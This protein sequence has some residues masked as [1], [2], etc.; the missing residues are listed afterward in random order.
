MVHEVRSPRDLIELPYSFT[1]LGLLPADKFIKEA[2]TRDIDIRPAALE[3]LHR[4][5]LLPP[6]LRVSRNRRAILRAARTQP[7]LAHQLAHWTG[8][9]AWSLRQD[10]AEGRVHDGFAERFTARERLRRT[11]GDD[12]YQA[13]YFLYSPH[14]LMLL[15]VL[16]GG[17]PHLAYDDAGRVVGIDVNKLW[18]SFARTRLDQGRE[19][20]VAV[21][22]LEARYL[23]T[24]TGR[25]ALQSS[26]EFVEYDRWRERQRLG[27]TLRWLGVRPAWL[28]DSAQGLLRHA[29]S[30]DPL[31]DWFDLV[32][33]ADPEWWGRLSGRAR[34]AIDLRIAAEILLRYYD[35]LARAGRAAPLPADEP[36]ARLVRTDFD[37]RLRPKRRLDELLTHFGLSPHPAV[38]LVLEGATEMLLV[39]R[40]MQLLGVRTS[41]DYI[42]VQDAEGVTTSISS[43]VAY[44]IAPRGV[45]DDSGRYIMLTRPLTR[46]VSVTDAEGPRATAA[47]RSEQRKTWVERMLRTLPTEQR[48]GEVR[49][50]LERLV[51]VLVWNRAGASFEFAHFS[52]RQIAVAID[53]LDRRPRRPALAKLTELVHKLRVCRGNLDNLLHGTSKPE[54]ADAL[55]PVLKSKIDRALT[56][57]TDGHI[58]VVRVVDRA[59]ELAR[60]MPRRNVVI[61]VKRR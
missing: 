33:E 42:R 20:V 55:W 61:P 50:S 4:L 57:G 27:S 40:V 41:D 32:R 51:H 36:G 34:S 11:V 45:L 28:R 52:D 38:L 5:G 29:R 24:I 39:P 25:L 54:L 23:P 58:P 9:Q 56:R 18:L 30:I 8:T 31:G 37:R 60:E 1:Q 16:A 48:T 49:G 44:A 59:A 47:Q 2:K 10:H 22:A 17:L 19:I 13:S 26:I 46:L 43:L 6:M 21:S 12:E 14:Q 35:D 7:M 53:A 15:P 3:G